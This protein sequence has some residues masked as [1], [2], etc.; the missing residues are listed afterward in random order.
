MGRTLWTKNIIPAGQPFDLRKR[1]PRPV[2]EKYFL[3]AFI[4]RPAVDNTTESTSLGPLAV[5]AVRPVLHCRS[6][7]HAAP[8][9]TWE[10]A[11]R[12]MSK[13]SA[14]P[15]DHGRSTFDAGRSCR[16]RRGP[17]P[18]DGRRGTCRA[19]TA[20]AGGSVPDD[21]DDEHPRQHPSTSH[22]SLHPPV[23]HGKPPPTAEASRTNR[24][25]SLR[26]RPGR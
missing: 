11:D 15:R 9:G 20:A 2:Y 16:R 22:R 24:T 17:V 19:Q 26:R 14:R 18:G 7:M 25:A 8:I 1:C 21:P 13:A 23:K 3:P 10:Y 4:H 5:P 6:V 12:G